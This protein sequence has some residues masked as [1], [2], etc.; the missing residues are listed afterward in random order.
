MTVRVVRGIPGSLVSISTFHDNF[1]VTKPHKDVHLRMNPG[2]P[3]T[4]AVS[5]VY[6][7]LYRHI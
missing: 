5:D 3:A 4:M 1:P 2:H 6:T 7:H